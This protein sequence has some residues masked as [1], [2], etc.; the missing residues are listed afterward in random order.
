MTSQADWLN[1]DP[2][3]LL[4]HIRQ[5]T[6]FDAELIWEMLEFAKRTQPAPAMMALIPLELLE[7]LFAGHYEIEDRQM[8]CL[9]VFP[10]KE[11]RELRAILADTKS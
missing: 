4:D 2:T 1:Y 7:R 11:V 3:F 6:N 9:Q 5:N 10:I 8:H